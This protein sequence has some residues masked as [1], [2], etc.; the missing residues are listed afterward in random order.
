M[1]E[2]RDF[3]T[4]PR[5]NSSPI[6]PSRPR[7][8][9]EKQASGSPFPRSP[10]PGSPINNAASTG[11]ESI[12]TLKRRPTRS[13]TA[14]SYGPRLKGRNW[15][16]GQ[17]PGIDTAAEHSGLAALHIKELSQKCDITVV[18]FSQDFVRLHRLD[19]E[20]LE[21]FLALPKDDWVQSRW[22]SVNGL[23]WDVIKLLG[24]YKGLHRL[25]IED[26]INPRNR[27][28]VDWYSDHT[29]SRLSGL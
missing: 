3:S 27:T 21:P 15:Q 11:R 20:S 23:S 7:I 13:N 6:R 19:N 4:E 22:I 26:L 12:D 16:P 14:R 18:D 24:N 1:S 2:S 29:Y 17:E 8:D 10:F 5:A 9:I 25:A 28:K